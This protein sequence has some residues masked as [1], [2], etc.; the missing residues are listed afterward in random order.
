[1][2]QA[3]NSDRQDEFSYFGMQSMW[4]VTKHMGGLK[5]TDELAALCGIGRGTRVLEV[6]SGVG[7]TSCHLAAKFGC[8]V[9]GVD[10]S[11]RMIEWATRRA[12]RKGLSEQAQFRIGDA[13]GLPFAEGSFDVVLCESVTAFPP[14]KQKAVNE[15][16]RV[17]R[18]GGMVGM[19]EGTWIRPD[20]PAELV[21]YCE[22]TMDGAHF[23]TPD[24]WRALLVKAGLQDLVVRPQ[25]VNAFRQKLD[26]LSGLEWEDWRER[27]GATGTVLRM[28][29][30]D[31]AFRRYARE[32]MPSMSNARALFYYLGYGLYVGSK[33]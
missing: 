27:L 32:L 11:A 30:R 21:S 24:G 33:P 16:T 29:A 25:T 31:P 3:E 2:G 20:P 1:M 23:L 6:G 17:A 18:A 28:Y 5:A 13:V 7:L 9:V 14:D 22:R 8:Q 15:Y 12:Q 10:L 19:N 26:E 4:G